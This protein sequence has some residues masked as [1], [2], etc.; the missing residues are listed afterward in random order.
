MTDAAAA[1]DTAIAVAPAAV[2]TSADGRWNRRAGASTS[3]GA[4][5]TDGRCST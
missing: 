1:D 2:A 4:R 3:R 5:R